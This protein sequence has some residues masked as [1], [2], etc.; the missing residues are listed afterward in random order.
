MVS[1]LGDI[2]IAMVDRTESFNGNTTGG[3]TVSLAVS[4]KDDSNRA[5]NRD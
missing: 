5:S 3:D 4:K 2:A 1:P